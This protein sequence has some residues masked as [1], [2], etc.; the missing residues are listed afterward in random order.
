MQSHH[1]LWTAGDQILDS[2]LPNCAAE[3]ELQRQLESFLKCEVSHSLSNSC[4]VL[5]S[6]QML[7]KGQALLSREA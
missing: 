5:G 2:P 3:S 4:I 7:S 1:R 6:Q